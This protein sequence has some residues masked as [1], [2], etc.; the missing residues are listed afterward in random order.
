MQ[1]LY[2]SRR[3]GMALLCLIALLSLSSAVALAEQ[4][5]VPIGQ[6]SE[7][8]TCSRIEPNGSQTFPESGANS[9]RLL[10]RFI[11][12]DDL[13]GH[14]FDIELQ[15][16]GTTIARRA[17]TTSGIGRRSIVLLPPASQRSSL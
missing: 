10:L 7:S 2:T 1:V 12:P 16:G 5:G 4:I 13:E 9:G 6:A 3:A 14:A 15:S 11:V 8:F 17:G